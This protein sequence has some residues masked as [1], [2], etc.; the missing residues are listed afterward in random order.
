MTSSPLQIAWRN[1]WRNHRRTLIML[2][3]IVIGV[4]AMIFMTATAH[5]AALAEGFQM[6]TS[7]V[8]MAIMA[9]QDHTATGKLKALIIPTGPS[10]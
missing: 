9:F 8:T 6:T 4:W 7:P 3:A 1:L 2:A 5:R 10:G